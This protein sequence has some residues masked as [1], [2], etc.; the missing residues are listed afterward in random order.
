MIHFYLHIS[1]LEVLYLL[2]GFGISLDSFVVAD[3]FY[4]LEVFVGFLDYSHFDPDLRIEQESF[5]VLF[6][7]SVSPA[8][9]F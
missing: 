4:N 7:R 6:S 9:I 8:I 3:V 2:F 1:L 5:Q